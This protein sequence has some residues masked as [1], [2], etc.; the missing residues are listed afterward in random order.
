VA[1][2]S[3]YDSTA[4]GAERLFSDNLAWGLDDSIWQQYGIRGQ[5]A[6]VLVKDGVIVDSWFGV[7]EEPE[8]RNK[9]D[10]LAG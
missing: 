10:A 2:R 6:T 4:A 9:L 3:D 7:L 1:G 8:L 5:P